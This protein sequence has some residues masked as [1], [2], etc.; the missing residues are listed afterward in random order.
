MI[1]VAKGVINHMNSFWEKSH[2]N[3]YDVGCGY[4]AL[5]WAWQQLGHTAW[6]NELNP[7]WVREANKF[8]DDKIF[9]ATFTKVYR[10]S[11]GHLIY[12]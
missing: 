10:E 9:S 3:I 12:F 2:W 6:G 8:C 5:V 11:K 7:T 4:G 1:T